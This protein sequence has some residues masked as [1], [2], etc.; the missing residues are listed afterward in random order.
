M[1]CGFLCLVFTL[2]EKIFSV[3]DAA[4]KLEKSS[5]KFDAMWPL[6]SILQIV[7]RCPAGAVS[8]VHI[9]KAAEPLF[10]A[11]FRYVCFFRIQRYMGVTPDVVRLS[12]LF[13][14]VCLLTKKTSVY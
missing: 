12:R 2:D 8:F 13:M 6:S 7:R 3:A 11:L 1:P 10:T 4:V 9:V 14:Y 5:N